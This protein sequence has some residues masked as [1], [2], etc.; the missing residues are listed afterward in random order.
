MNALVHSSGFHASAGDV[1]AE[2]VLLLRK[3]DTQFYVWQ[4]STEKH[5]FE[6]VSLEAPRQQS[7]KLEERDSADPEI[8]EQVDRALN[9]LESKIL[10]GMLEELK[11]APEVLS[12][13]ARLMFKNSQFT[14][15]RVN[16]EM[17]FS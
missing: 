8:V 3:G 9:A 4:Q 15:A 7:L 13:E 1:G 10:P 2:I 5:R 12:V 14:W 17:K 16:K 11:S 6:W